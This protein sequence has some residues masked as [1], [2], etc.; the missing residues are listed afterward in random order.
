MRNID[1]DAQHTAT[2]ADADAARSGAVVAK[3]RACL[4]QQSD[5]QRHDD[6]DD[7][8]CA[9]L[10]DSRQVIDGIDVDNDQCECSDV[11]GRV[12]SGRADIVDQ[13]GARHD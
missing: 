6:D 5:A 3:R 13:I 7:D 10:V 1:D 11:G 9:S 4:E 8:Y 12:D 2:I